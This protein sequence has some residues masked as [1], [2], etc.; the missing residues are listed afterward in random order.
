MF[1][2]LQQHK[3]KLPGTPTA[4]CNQMHASGVHAAADFVG[5]TG[6]FSDY[7]ALTAHIRFFFPNV[8]F[9][10]LE[11]HF[12]RRYKLISLSFPVTETE[13]IL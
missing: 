11:S 10:K 5:L 7:N 4:R 3:R 6:F 13:D 8:L 1:Y 2:I 12:I 9:V